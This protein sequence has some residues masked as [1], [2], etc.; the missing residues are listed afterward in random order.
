MYIVLQ[1][2]DRNAEFA[3]HE[4]TWMFPRSEVIHRDHTSIPCL[5]VVNIDV[6]SRKFPKVQVEHSLMGTRLLDAED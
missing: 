3:D 6:L 1:L 4:K 5:V 2:T